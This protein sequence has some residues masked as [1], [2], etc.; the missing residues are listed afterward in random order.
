MEI[1][2]LMLHTTLLC[3][4]QV[5]T[6]VYTELFARRVCWLEHVWQGFTKNGQP[7]LT[8]LVKNGQSF[9][10]SF[11]KKWPTMFDQVRKKWPTM[12]DRQQQER[13]DSHHCEW[14][15]CHLQKIRDLPWCH[16]FGPATGL[17]HIAENVYL[18][19]L[20]TISKS[21]KSCDCCHIALSSDWQLI[22]SMLSQRLLN[23]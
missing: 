19:Q 12:F 11:A 4:I 20:S 13:C 15:S 3:T 22:I 16:Y 17:Q 14:H 1:L 18:A 23:S 5:H 10:T 21:F 8:R 9:L 2:D 6:C 7:Y